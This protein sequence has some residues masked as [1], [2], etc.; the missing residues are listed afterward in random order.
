MT[1]MHH[2]RLHNQLWSLVILSMAQEPNDVP[3]GLPHSKHRVSHQTTSISMRPPAVYTFVI[4][5]A[6]LHMCSLYVSQ[7]ADDVSN[8]FPERLPNPNP[9]LR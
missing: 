2:G 4:N 8:G 1:W 3:N 7:D 6:A 9:H 5:L